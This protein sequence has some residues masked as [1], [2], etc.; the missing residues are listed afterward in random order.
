MQD[1]IPTM[2]SPH[3]LAGLA[4]LHIEGQDTNAFLNGQLTQTVPEAAGSV[5][6]AG[7]CTPQGR[8]LATPRLYR[9]ADGALEM[10]LPSA[11]AEAV[12]ARMRKFVMRSKVVFTQ[13]E[14]A[15]SEQP[16]WQRLN[17]REA[18][19]AWAEA[20][21]LAGRP[22]VNSSAQDTTPAERF[23]PQMVNLDL[24]D[25]VG[26]SK[27]CYPGQEIVART[28]YLG[29]SL[30]RAAVFAWPQGLLSLNT[31]AA[32]GG[33]GP[34]GSAEPDALEWVWA[35]PA[36]SLGPKAVLAMVSLPNGC[37]AAAV[38]AMAQAW[39]AQVHPLPYAVPMPS[40]AVRPKLG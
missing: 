4:L 33:A 23:T 37:E 7:Y 32:Q 3:G 36:P 8:L 38:S 17:Q 28:H 29:K 10:L 24:V 30:K 20:E 19:M 14:F 16:A 6:L 2:P 13:M 12:V 35:S 40:P 25:G 22:W 15:K 31:T 9:R 5:G 27:G 11:S 1:T 39:H 18:Q 26:F 34:S 21:L